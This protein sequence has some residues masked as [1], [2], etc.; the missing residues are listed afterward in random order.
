MQAKIL[1][2]PLEVAKS[3]E[4]V[5]PNLDSILGDHLPEP[6]QKGDDLAR[7]S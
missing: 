4:R 2:G 6:G 5:G 1:G 3:I 7:S